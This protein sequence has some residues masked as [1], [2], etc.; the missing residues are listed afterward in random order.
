MISWWHRINKLDTR[1]V[2]CLSSLQE[3]FSIEVDN[4]KYL[5]ID[6]GQR[7]IRIFEA[8]RDLF[9][10]ESEQKPLV[11]AVEDLHWIDMSS[12]WSFKKR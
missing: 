6:P 1:L 11:L 2:G 9:L 5:Q 7:K 8:V 12:Q 10:L 3:L 4:E